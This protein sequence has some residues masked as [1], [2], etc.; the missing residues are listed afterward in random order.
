MIYQGYYLLCFNQNQEITSVDGGHSKPSGVSQALYLINQL[1]LNK[2]GETYCM[3]KV[4]QDIAV[5]GSWEKAFT[6][7]L[8]TKQIRRLKVPAKSKFKVNSEALSLM[9]TVMQALKKAD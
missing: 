8:S 5:D 6:S 4:S 9:K 7:L 2:E 1:S 3:V